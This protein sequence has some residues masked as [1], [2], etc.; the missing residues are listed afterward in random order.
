VVGI[1]GRRALTNYFEARLF[2]KNS[3]Q[4]LAKHRVIVDEKE[5]NVQKASLD[6]LQIDNK[7]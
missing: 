2:L 3:R 4:S 6:H 1:C 5:I 7:A